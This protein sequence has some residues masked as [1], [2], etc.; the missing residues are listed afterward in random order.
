MHLKKI[1][2]ALALALPLGVAAQSQDQLIDRYTKLAGSKQNATSLVNG[3]RDGAQ[4]RL[5]KGGSIESFTPPTGKMGYGNVDNTLALAEASL[6][7]KGVT[8]PTPVQLEAA[9]MEIT[10]M[11]A[12]GKG[13]GQIAD[14]KGF[15][16]GEV[17]RPEHVT[18]VERAHKPERPERP[19]K[20][21]RPERPERPEKPHKPR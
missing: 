13:W 11:R 9:V 20:P 14:A 10:R 3:L 1:V 2:I 16:L 17:K 7:K 19:E 12:E 4:V 18:K 15:K 6:Q 8:N 21:E 5:I